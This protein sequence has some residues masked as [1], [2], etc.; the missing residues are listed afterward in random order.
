MENSSFILKPESQKED[1][2]IRPSSFEEFIGQQDI[3]DNLKIYI[4]AA[5][6]RNE[7]LDHTLF[8]GPPGLGKTTLACMIS[9]IQEA[10]FHQISAPNLKRPGDLAKIL[11]NLDKDDVLFIDEIH[12]LPSP[13]EEILYP[14]MEDGLIDITLAEGMAASS[15]QINLPPF[16][17]VGAT[18]RPGALSAPLID[19][20]GI[21]LRL[22]YY[23]DDEL[24]LIIQR[25]AKIWEIKIKDDAI[26]TISVRSRKTPRI[27]IRLLRR[28]WDHSMVRTDSLENI[29]DKE[30][31]EISFKKMKIDFMGLT[32]TDNHFL[33]VLA[34]DYQGGPVGLKPL[35]AIIS[36]DLIT[37]EDFIEPF[38]VRLGFVKRTP[39]GRILTPIAYEHLHLKPKNLKKRE[40]LF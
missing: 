20:F 30:I 14:A 2:S 16:T 23:E 8:S 22:N 27:A 35:A 10:R 40:K 12:R 26:Q 9:K 39:R 3:V 32:S 17:L 31:V 18:T 15:I 21:H 7:P 33:K 13:V 19:R 5:K 4:Q 37:L 34:K 29:I 11:T 24:N 38:L 28:I 36:E 1:Q 6:M 25:S